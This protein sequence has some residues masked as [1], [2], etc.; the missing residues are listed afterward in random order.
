[1]RHTRMTFVALLGL[2]VSCST[3]AASAACNIKNFDRTPPHAI[4]SDVDNQFAHFEWASDV[5]DRN[6][7]VWIW[8]YIHNERYDAGLGAVWKK[9]GIRIPITHPLPPKEVFCNRYLVLS[10]RKK[11][12]TDAPIVYG[13]NSQNQRAAVYLSE[14]AKTTSSSVNSSVIDKQG[15]VRSLFVNI[16][17]GPTSI[18]TYFI[19][20]HSPNL[21]IA[22]PA[23]A[24]FLSADQFGMFR[25]QL[26]KQK[27]TATK[28]PYYKL[29]MQDPYKTFAQLYSKDEALALAK[30]ELVFI[31]GSS[32][33]K[34]EIPAK[35]TKE[36]A[37]D[38]I[39]FNEDYEPMF[40]TRV[41]LLLPAPQ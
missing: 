19:L 3:V 39:V 11:P 34:T 32:I 5:D 13:T 8:N 35:K 9:A 1:M 30:D 10:A 14:D 15:K 24:K 27:A 23:L 31:G 37:T 18:G 16:R 38:M 36:V 4:K 20:E 7:Q 41:R 6:G 21:M 12:D 25:N 33:V 28:G 29:A 22:I 2:A 40:A 26:S 17:T